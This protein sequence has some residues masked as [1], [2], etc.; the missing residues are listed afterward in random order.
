[1]MICGINFVDWLV[2]IGKGVNELSFYCCISPPCFKHRDYWSWSIYL[3]IHPSIYIYI[4]IYLSIYLYIYPSIYLRLS[5]AIYGYLWLSMAIYLS[6]QSKVLPSLYTFH[7]CDSLMAFPVREIPESSVSL[8]HCLT[9]TSQQR[10]LHL[11]CSL[12]LITSTQNLP[13]KANRWR[14]YPTRQKL[15]PSCVRLIYCSCYRHIL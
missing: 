11:T 1:M 6:V 12:R 2:K 15:L 10:P 8:L 14:H 4:S 9:A 3:S 5:M 13:P 7:F